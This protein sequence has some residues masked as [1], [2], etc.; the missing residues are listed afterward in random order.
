MIIDSHLHLSFVDANPSTALD[1]LQKAREKGV[2]KF[3]LVGLSEH[4]VAFNRD[5][6]GKT[7][8]VFHILGKDPHTAEK[9]SEGELVFFEAAARELSPIAIG[10]I[11]LDYFHGA[12]KKKIQRDIFERMLALADDT[13]LPAVFHCRDAQDDLL[14]IVD[15]FSLR[16]GAVLHCFTG[17]YGFAQ[18]LLDRGFIISFSG[19]VTFKSAAA[20][21]EVVSKIPLDRFIVETDAPYLAPIPW[22]GRKNLPEYLPDTVACIAQLRKTSIAEI[23]R[24][25]TANFNRFFGTPA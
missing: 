17:G 8:D 22:R 11:G 25:T 4:D 12:D 10:E 3:V 15:N 7:K 21:R 18:K 6:L 9:A 16:R 20:V 24:A 1:I 5:I 2:A 23:E 13:D 19:I 14:A